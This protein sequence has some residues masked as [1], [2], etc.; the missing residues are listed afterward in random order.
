MRQVCYLVLSSGEILPFFGFYPARSFFRQAT[1]QRV[2]YIDEGFR[3]GRKGVYIVTD[4]DDGT[5]TID[6][7]QQGIELRTEC[8][9]DVGIRLV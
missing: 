6:F 4:E 3:Q 7:F 5:A 8:L 2:I 1:F 9:V